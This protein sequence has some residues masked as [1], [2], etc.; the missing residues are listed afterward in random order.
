V[1]VVFAYLL[2]P[3][4]LLGFEERDWLLV[5]DFRHPEGEEELARALKLAMT[6]GVQESGYVNVV[7]RPQIAGVLQQMQRPPDIAVDEVVGREICQ[8]ANVKGPL[9]RQGPAQDPSRRETVVESERA[10]NSLTS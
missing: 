3:S 5:A 4:P 10:S 9:A 8:R 1:A 2:N 7:S 6:V